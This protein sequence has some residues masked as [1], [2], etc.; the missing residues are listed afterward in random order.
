[1]NI[2]FTTKGDVTTAVQTLDG[3][4]TTIGKFTLNDDA[5]TFKLSKGIELAEDAYNAL[6]EKFYA[7]IEKQSDAQPD[8]EEAAPTEPDFPPAPD[9]EQG[10]AGHE[11]MEYAA[12]K[13]DDAQFSELYLDRW[14]RKHFR[15][16]SEK[17]PVFTKRATDLFP[18][19]FI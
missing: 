4:K 16:W 7:Y 9:P 6:T 2:T 8:E 19:D 3:K 13:F 14:T 17:C 18:P 10:T 1:M 5:F 11:Y 12:K 15:Q